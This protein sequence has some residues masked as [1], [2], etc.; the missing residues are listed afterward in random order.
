MPILMGSSMFCH[1]A[2]RFI[3]NHTNMG[4]NSVKFYGCI[5]FVNHGDDLFQ[6]FDMCVQ[7]RKGKKNSTPAAKNSSHQLRKRG[8]LGRRAP[9]PEKKRAV[10][11]GQ[12]GCGQTS[13][14]TSPD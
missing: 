5:C 7:R 9:S 11:E 12:E 1:S 13:Q 10:S 8:H 14:Q 6:E 2:G 3:S 4:F